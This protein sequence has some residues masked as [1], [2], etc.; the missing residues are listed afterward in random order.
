MWRW[1]T[2]IPPRHARS[3][4]ATWSIFHPARTEGPKRHHFARIAEVFKFSRTDFGWES[5]MKVVFVGPDGIRAGWRF[6]IFSLLVFSFSKLFF[7]F[8][9]V[10]FHYQEHAGWFPT[11]FLL[12]GTLSFGAALLAAL[13]MSKLE[14]RPFQEY[15]LPWQLMFHMHFWQGVLWGFASSLLMMLL[16]RLFGAAS[17][18]GIAQHGRILFQSA[19]LWAAAFLL[20]GFAEEFVYRGYLQTTLTTGMGFWPAAVLLSSVFGAVHYFFKPMENWIDGVSVGLFGLFWCFTLRRTGTLW[21][22]IGFHAMSDYADMVLFAQPN[23]GNNGQSLTGHLLNVFYNGPE[24][25]TG[26]P[27][28]TEASVLEFLIL[29]LMFLFFARAYPRIEARLATSDR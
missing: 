3:R 7:W 20:L 13:I 29:A 19:L 2:F 4:G 22:A 6:A 12:D 27:R 10:F 26:G 17:F 23:T 9:T 16:L 11:D 8:L 24:W 25:L 5:N 18:G 15:G 28:G 14:R 21:F 1:T